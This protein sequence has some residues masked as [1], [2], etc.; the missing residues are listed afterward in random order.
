MM[1]THEPSAVVDSVVEAAA[2]VDAPKSCDPT[3]FA[4]FCA[5]ISRQLRGPYVT[6]HGAENI[7]AKLVDLFE[8]FSERK[9]ATISARVKYLGAR[10]VNIQTVMSDQPFIVNTV[11][12][13]MTRAHGTYQS[14]FNAVFRVERD[15]AGR[16]VS[17]GGDRG[18]LESIVQMEAEGMGR[19]DAA[20]ASELLAAHLALS[21]A[22][23]EDFQDMTAEIERV[24]AHF[25][26]LKRKHPDSAG[27]HREVRD[28]LR[29]LVEDNFV[30]M[31]V[32]HGDVALGFERDEGWADGLTAGWPKGAGNALPVLVRKGERD[33]PV[34]RTGRLDEIRIDVP[35]T[36]G[37]RV[38]QLYVQGLFTYRA[39]TQPSRNIPLLRT[40]L[41]SLLKEQKRRPGSFSYKGV[42]NV[43]DSLPTEFLF[44]ASKDEIA[45]LVEVVRDAEHEQR[46]QLDLVQELDSANTTFALAAMPKSQYSNTLQ[47]R[48][49]RRL[50][51]ATAASYCDH[52]LFMSRYDTVLLHFYLVGAK[53]LDRER[54]TKLHGELSELVTPWVDRVYEAIAT[55]HGE[56]YADE[57]LARF[58]A[59]FPEEY[60]TRTSSEQ[61]LE[62]LD[63]LVK[64]CEERPVTAG[65]FVDRRGRTNVRL[66]Q[67]GDVILTDILPV[68]DNFGLLIIDQFSDPVTPQDS[69]PANIDTFR[70]QAAWG[71]GLEQVLQR[72]DVLTDAVEAVFANRV[73]NDALN[74]LVLAAELPWQ[75]VDL[76]RAYKGH[77]RQLGVKFPAV[78]VREIL[79]AHPKMVGRLVGY[80]YAR[81]DPD[82]DGDRDQA[83]AAAAEIIEGGL[84]RVGNHDEDVL[85]RSLYTLM[86]ATLRTNFFRTD[87]VAHY[88]S[89]KVDHDA[90]DWIPQPK[91]KYEVYIHH[92]EMEGVHLRGGKIARG[93]IRWSDRVDYRTEVLGLATTQMVKNVLIVPEGAKGGFYMKRPP[94]DWA[95]RRA[96]ADFLYT[97]LA[98]GLLDLTDN[99][100]H[101]RVV[102][103]PRVVRH[104]EDDT[105]LV[106]AADKG[107]AHLSDTANG[108]S[109]EY[110]FW[111]DDAF[112]SGGSNGYDHKVC[113]ITARGGWVCVRRHFREMGLDQDSKAFTAVGIGDPSGDVFGNGVIEH[114]TMKL[115]AAFNHRHIFLDPD[116][117][118]K[119]TYQERKR[120]FDAASGWDAY[121]QT[122][123]SEGGGIF[124]RHA[125]SI[126]LS[127]QTKKMLGALE[128]ELSADSVLR[129]ILRMPVDLFWNGGIGTYV[130]ASHESHRQAGD[131]TND[132]CRVNA[133]EIQ[134]KSIGEG[135]NLGLTQAARIEY[136]LAGG[137]LNTDATDNSG[138]VDMS[139]HEV[140]LKILLSGLVASGRLDVEARN[141]FI[142]ELTDEIA[143]AVL[144]NNDVHARQISLDQIRSATDP[145]PFDRTI[146][147]VCRE[148]GLSRALLTLPSSD[149]IGRRRGRRQG[150]AR[151]ELAVLQAHVKM[152][153]YKALLAADPGRFPG[154]DERVRRYFPK[155]VQERYPE[156]IDGHML[157][158]AI[159]MTVNL[160]E[161]VGDMG[162]AFFPS[163]MELT[164]RPPADIAVA[165]LRAA[166]A[167]EL[168]QL[169]K[170]FNN[171]GAKLAGLY[172]AWIYVAN[173]LWGL[174]G[175]CLA[176]GQPELTAAELD[177]VVRIMGRM[178]RLRPQEA[179]QTHARRVKGLLD[180]GV[181]RALAQ[182]CPGF[183]DLT[184]AREIAALQR[185]SGDGDRDAIVRYLAI[186]QASRLLPTIA[187]MESQQGSGPWD[188]VAN[189]LLR[190]RYLALLRQLAL[191][192][193]L[194]GELR[195]S[196][197][198]A[199]H[200]LYWDGGLRGFADTMQ[201]ILG[202][203]PDTSA[204]L[205]AEERLKASWL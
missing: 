154:F 67:L 57:V 191:S 124:D 15:E 140:N 130:K 62:D 149:E 31:G 128:D 156:A 137:R 74:R 101:G 49:Q 105:Y 196:V 22:M 11:R 190:S 187:A 44:T 177:D 21:R 36:D 116:P 202:D 159:G 50:V 195:L 16:V 3:L 45:N 121:D 97:F 129:K 89:F 180:K 64:L 75:D 26:R 165:W 34:H 48:M 6:R 25:D 189:G 5:E 157:H 40:V 182:R 7:P 112:A 186:G 106:V 134:A 203:S 82:L 131:S 98:R 174:M 79:L 143:V 46:V 8:L 43:F 172:R 17:L 179:S 184:V 163:L 127:P 60:T 33:S 30:F 72:A 126:K 178:A 100:V 115:L 81:F 66:Y 158:T 10:R 146:H 117:D 71:L 114:P 148:E 18:E 204:Y 87:R 41:A 141:A 65:V 197:D 4:A 153:V 73:A 151:P 119:K 185:E 84:R 54:L 108:V 52:G 37:R 56:E 55:A 120:L 99:I 42:T 193:H 122:L 59:A 111:L 136:A 155:A 205:V 133:D 102:A 169:R 181:P 85:L 23:V 91:L 168:D 188:F 51:R 63:A 199:A 150:L 32:R 83:M 183:L 53:H 109:R 162:A 164:G 104:D 176:P 39:L 167:L 135:G 92:A 76:I 147:W 142:E 27:P 113:G 38:S 14:G 78:R 61:A 192:V 139:D 198:R 103:P 77:L 194:G 20:Q 19:A 35:G 28:F 118:P 145:F 96:K 93:G 138:G 58:G 24:A 123:L 201:S 9:P 86:T 170:S 47:R 68:L 90:V 70:L 175:G 13:M 88:I 173:G 160:M 1:R 125:K 95:E 107:T 132:S 166:D 2:K 12:L 94:S 69:A 144:A 110:G 80:F 171:S 161:I 152:R 200:R 29:W